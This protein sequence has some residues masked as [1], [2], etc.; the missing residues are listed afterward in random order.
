MA[1]T[2]QELA[3]K[4]WQQV[5]A[6]EK[7]AAKLWQRVSAYKAANTPQNEAGLVVNVIRHQMVKLDTKAYDQALYAIDKVGG[8]DPVEKWEKTK[9]VF[10]DAHARVED[11]LL[12]ALA[13]NQEL[14]KYLAANDDWFAGKSASLGECPEDL[15]Y[16]DS[17]RSCVAR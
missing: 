7:L 11:I 17:G 8:S 13:P 16:L 2:T 12:L 5:D 1:T 15:S 9:G 14:P 4:L 6:G 10:V 3:A